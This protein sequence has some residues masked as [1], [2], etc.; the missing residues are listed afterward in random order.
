MDINL[1]YQTKE[2]NYNAKKKTSA[3]EFCGNL[4]I[5][6]KKVNLKHQKL[7]T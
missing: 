4:Y 5:Y 6:F 2:N 3:R 1:V 7:S